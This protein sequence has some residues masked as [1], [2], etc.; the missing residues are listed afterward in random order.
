MEAFIKIHEWKLN[1]TVYKNEP[2]FTISLCSLCTCSRYI[3]TSKSI[4][5]KMRRRFYV[6]ILITPY[7]QSAIKLGI[8]FCLI[9]IHFW[10]LIFHFHYAHR[11]IAVE[12]YSRQSADILREFICTSYM[13]I[14]QPNTLTHCGFKR[15]FVFCSVFITHLVLSLLCKQNNFLLNFFVCICAGFVCDDARLI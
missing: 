7:C 15:I 2:K 1:C 4:R 8:F 5:T 6:Y 9:Q 13:Y 3:W 11:F 14:E 12:L 10:N